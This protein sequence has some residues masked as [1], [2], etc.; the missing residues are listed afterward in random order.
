[1]LEITSPKTANHCRFGNFIYF[2]KRD[3]GVTEETK[4]HYTKCCHNNTKRQL[5][6]HICAYP[7]QIDQ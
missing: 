7:D 3:C 1:M 4:K 5:N 2:V 6:M